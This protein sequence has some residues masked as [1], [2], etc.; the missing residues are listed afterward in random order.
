MENWNKFLLIL[1]LVGINGAQGYNPVDVQQLLNLEYGGGSCD[2]PNSTPC[3]LSN[4][5]FTQTYGQFAA[6]HPG[7]TVTGLNPNQTIVEILNG[8]VESSVGNGWLADSNREC[9]AEYGVHCM[10]D[11]GEKSN[12]SGAN[13][14]GLNLDNAFMVNANLTGANQTNVNTDSGTD[15]GTVGNEPVV[16]VKQGACTGSVL[17]VQRLLTNG[18]CDIPGSPCDLSKIDFT[19]TYGKFVTENPGCAV[20]GLNPNQTL[21]EI[22]NG[23][24]ASS[25][26][27]FGEWTNFSDA[28]IT[29]LNL[30]N[31]FLPGAKFIDTNMTNVNFD[32]KTNVTNAVFGKHTI[33]NSA[34]VTGVDFSGLDLTFVTFNG[35]DLTG[36]KFNGAI[37]KDVQ[38]VGVHGENTDF[39]GANGSDA[40]ASF[41][42]LTAPSDFDGASFD[43]ANL[44]NS[45]FV[46]SFKNAHFYGTD[47]YQTTMPGYLDITG[48]EGN[49]PGHS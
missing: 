30:G 7:Y 35:T 21:V 18:S 6:Q 16:A 45:T 9:Y 41:G 33:G 8:W 1:T 22:L 39:S 12:L 20:P 48:A 4:F 31:A 28:N 19:Q 10:L 34:N 23:W 11:F 2:N 36:A 38:F 15:F 26:L 27:N 49:Y 37:I 44:A 40:G 14:T 25:G 46:G 13:L 32:S 42:I 17:N 5:D 24:A 29:G 43:G 3:D 47:T